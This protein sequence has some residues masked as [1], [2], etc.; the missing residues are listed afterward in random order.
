MNYTYTTLN[1]AA[2]DHF[3]EYGFVVIANV[4]DPEQDFQPLI[5]E[6]NGV[7]DTLSEQL[8][9]EG[10]LTSTYRD[11]PLGKRFM[12]ITT[13]TGE[14]HA[15]PFDIS[16]PQAGVSETTPIHCG[17][18]IFA[19]LRHPRLLDLVETFIG[20]EIYSN[21]VQHSRFKVPLSSMPQGQWD[22]LTGTIGLH[23]DQGVR[24]AGSR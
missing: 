15:Q 19:L 5:E 20:P 14:L 21:P 6:Y 8:H 11:L 16:L 10:K 12:Q 9:A 4:F 24:A 3:A 1:Q 22:G 18:A 13:E 7:L 2:L 17:E 23:Q